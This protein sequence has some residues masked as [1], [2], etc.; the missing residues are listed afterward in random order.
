MT[1]GFGDL[2]KGATIELDGQPY[3]VIDYERQKMQ[4][5]APVTRLKLRNLRDGR[6]MQ[7]T[8][9]SYTTEFALAQVDTRETQYLYNDGEFYHFMD[10]ENYEQ[11]QLTKEQVSENTNFLT[12]GIVLEIRS[13]TWAAS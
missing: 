13:N 12:D 11:Y 8:F 1:I 2:H 10:M 5:R 6:V 9:Q 3:E 4:Q 7:R